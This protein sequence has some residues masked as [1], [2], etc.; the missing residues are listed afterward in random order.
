MH[1]YRLGSLPVSEHRLDFSLGA[2]IVAEIH[3][4]SDKEVGS[5]IS[6]TRSV[7]EGSD[8]SVWD[9][10]LL[11]V[12]HP[13]RIRNLHPDPS[14]EVTAIWC[15]NRI[16]RGQRWLFIPPSWSY[17]L[18]SC[19][20]N[21]DLLNVLRRN[22]EHIASLI[23]DESPDPFVASGAL[24]PNTKDWQT[25]TDSPIDMLE[26]VESQL[27][28]DYV[29]NDA[30]WI[31]WKE[32]TGCT[33]GVEGGFGF[34]VAI[35]IGEFS[36]NSLRIL[37]FA[38]RG[39]TGLGDPSRWQQWKEMILVVEAP[40]RGREGPILSKASDDGGNTHPVDPDRTMSAYWYSTSTSTS[41]LPPP[42]S[43]LRSAA[44]SPLRH[45]FLHPAY[46]VLLPI[47]I[48]STALPASDTSRVRDIDNRFSCLRHRR[49]RRADADADK[50]T[51][52][53]NERTS[54]VDVEVNAVG[55]RRVGVGERKADWDGT[56]W[57]ALGKRQGTSST[58]AETVAGAGG[59]RL[60]T[61]ED[62]GGDVGT[63][64]GTEGVGYDKGAP[65]HPRSSERASS[66]ATVRDATTK[67][68]A[69]K[70]SE[71]ELHTTLSHGVLHV[72]KPQAL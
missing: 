58:D 7:L 2:Y 48:V 21:P 17:I 62:S 37:E 34:G 14:L 72:A 52:L 36:R 32:F 56:A 63:G 50:K 67:K 38:E 35:P 18:R 33:V 47:M 40:G 3:Q 43:P 5:I 54:H 16:G 1:M 20:P 53:A 39:L 68:A 66:T 69:R 46:R 8:N 65:S 28:A 70:R 30:M 29:E 51:T 24:N 4:L 11:S 61:T 10:F 49:R 15:L 42:S 55:T 71:E 64:K 23:N 60:Y 59:V 22:E 19:P 44:P 45:L 13:T 6:A 57:R 9:A 31:V 26:Y 25:F 27:P 12:A 41:S